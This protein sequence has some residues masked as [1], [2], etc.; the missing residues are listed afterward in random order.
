VPR[1]CYQ[2]FSGRKTAISDCCR[3]DTVRLG[4]RFRPST[5]PY[6]CSRRR[7]ATTMHSSH[8]STQSRQPP[9]WSNSSGVNNR[10]SAIAT[11]KNRSLGIHANMSKVSSGG[12]ERLIWGGIACIT[13]GPRSLQKRLRVWSKISKHIEKVAF[14]ISQFLRTAFL[15]KP[16]EHIQSGIDDPV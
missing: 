3:Y 2:L 14:P 4:S 16:Q 11:A 1:L 6:S 8:R 12:W 13:R 5:T 9:K 10:S 7:P 15:L